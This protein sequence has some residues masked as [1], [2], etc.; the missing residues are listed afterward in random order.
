M[1]Q[2]WVWGLFWCFN[3]VSEVMV[4]LLLFVGL[5]SLGGW[6]SSANV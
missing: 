6:F 1:F 4:V 3:V 2:W 5:V